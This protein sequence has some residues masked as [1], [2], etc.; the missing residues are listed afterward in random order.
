MIVVDLED[1]AVRP[2]YD[3]V[4]A[5]VYGANRRNVRTT[6]LAGEPWTRPDDRAMAKQSE[7]AA[8]RLTAAFEGQ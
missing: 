3:P 7:A 4:D 2:I 6:I 1:P 8:L 5:L